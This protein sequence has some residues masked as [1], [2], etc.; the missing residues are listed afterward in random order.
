MKKLI[1]ALAAVVATAGSACAFPKALYVKKGETYTKYNLGVASDMQFSEGGKTLRITGYDDVINLDEVDYIQFSA[2][3]GQTALTPAQ[4]KE[5]LVSIG[6]AANNM[7]D[8][9]KHA[10]LLNLTHSFFDD[11][12]NSEWTEKIYAAPVNFSF[13]DGFWDKNAREIVNAASRIVK[14]DVNAL[15]ALT[16]RAVDV[17]KASDYLGAFT[18]DATTEKWVKTSD[19][20]YFEM[21]FT[22]M[23]GE[24]FGVKIEP[25]DDH[26]D[27]TTSDGKVEMPRTVNITFSKDG[28][29]LAT[30]K[31][32][33]ELQDGKKISLA[34]DFE[35]NGYVAKTTMDVVDTRIQSRS[36]VTIG[37]KH[38]VTA[39]SVIHGDHLVDYDE[40]K[41]SW[42][43]AKDTYDETSGYDI[44]GDKTRLRS[45]FSNAVA[46][47]DLMG[48]LQVSGKLFRFSKVMDI[49]DKD[50]D[51]VNGHVL[52]KDGLYFSY[53]NGKDGGLNADKSIL[54]VLNSSEEVNEDKVKYLNN[55]ADVQFSYDGNGQLQGFLGF[56]TSEDDEEY[57][58]FGGDEYNQYGSVVFNGYVINVTR[59]YNPE[60]KM[61]NDWHV[62]VYPMDKDGNMDYSSAQS[63]TFP[64]SEVLRNSVTINRYYEVSPVITFNDLTSYSFTD[65]FDETS[66][67]KL[68]DDYNDLIDTYFSI[69]GQQR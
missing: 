38:F 18:A 35:S 60:T 52:Y 57:S 31:L 14:G 20:K 37:G 59:E 40:M 51:V 58:G 46:D 39:N 30:A 69:T 19:A 2:P 12:W 22:G 5:R 65:F 33:S 36:S 27:W 48:Q 47:V 26:T 6:E 53:V 64:D 4:Q 21:L 56:E 67:T 11:V 3:T 62:D 15:R 66:F 25:S 24:K 13:P 16:A 34:L 42:D 10:D 50:D 8:I 17:Y 54:T 1:L 23:K 63:A 28:K 61:W 41:G 44:D 55:Y 29:A 49:L 68:I 9:N 32:T 45:H 7:V 43:E